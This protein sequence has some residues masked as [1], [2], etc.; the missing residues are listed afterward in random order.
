MEIEGLSAWSSSR[1]GWLIIVPVSVV[2]VGI[3]LYFAPIDLMAI[4]PI[5]ATGIPAL[6]STFSNLKSPKTN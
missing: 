4:L 5:F 3:V 2:S 1:L 6:I